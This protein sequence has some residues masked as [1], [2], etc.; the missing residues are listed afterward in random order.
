MKT[1]TIQLNDMKEVLAFV[2]K[3]G[4]C[5]EITG[6]VGLGYNLRKGTQVAHFND[7]AK[8]VCDVD[9]E[10]DYSEITPGSGWSVHFY[11]E[12]PC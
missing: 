7:G 10:P 9:F 3:H 12:E 4:S 1:K 6:K 2:W 11:G 5:S 8:L